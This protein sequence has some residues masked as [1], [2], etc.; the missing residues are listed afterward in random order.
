MSLRN[1]PYIPL[2]VQDFL[3]DEK[4]MECSASATGIYIRL[5]CIMHK[6]D[7]YGVILLKQKDKQNSS[8]L[9]NFAYKLA[10]FMPYQIDEIMAGLTEL[11]EAGVIQNGGDKLTQKRMIHD[12]EISEI[13]AKAGKKGGLKSQNFAKAKIEAKHEYEYTNEIVIDLYKGIEIFFDEDCRPK[14]EKA[15]HEW[16]DTLDKLIRIDGY[17]PEHIHDVIKRARMDDFWRTN[18]LSVLKLR[19][20]NKEGIMYFTVFEKKLL[21]ETTGRNNQ[22]PASGEELTSFYSERYGIK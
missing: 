14:T 1:Q 3:T 20:K 17:T 8:S 15:K 18:F 21:H 11:L 13:R 10:R 5:M 2:Y 9:Q 7:E 4:L 16:Y 12:N 22:K 6:S 19:K